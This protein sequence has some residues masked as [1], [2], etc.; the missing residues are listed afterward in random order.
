MA[1]KKESVKVETASATLST[2]AKVTGPKAV[3]DKMKGSA[4]S[5]KSSSK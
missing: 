3:I 2:G 4:A 5:A 1:S